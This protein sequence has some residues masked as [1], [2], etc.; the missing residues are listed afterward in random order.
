LAEHESDRS[1]GPDPGEVTALLLRWQA[2]DDAALELLAP[3]VYEEL[4]RVARRQMRRE[5]E[6]HTLEP[7]AVVHEAYLR[8]VAQSRAQW[9]NRAQFYA[10]AARL[11]RRLLL[12]HARDRRAQKR[13]GAAT[14]ITLIEAD[15][16]AA[17]REVDLIDLDRALQRLGELDAEQEKLVELRFF[18]GLTVEETAETLG[19][20]PATVKRDWQSARAWLF[21]EL[22]AP[23]P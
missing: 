20:S 14:R 5:R 21:A 9:Q 22:A 3:L 19:S 4:R 17:P 8:L 10:V 15:A 1:N 16:V 18:G 7:T 11:M 23:R 12:N 13:G 6:A 2:G